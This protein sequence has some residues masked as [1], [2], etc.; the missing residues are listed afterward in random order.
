M[1]IYF[2]L[3]TLWSLENDLNSL[4]VSDMHCLPG[5]ILGTED[6]AAKKSESLI[7]KNMQSSQ[8]DKT[9]NRM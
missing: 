9:N 3:S 8:G 6:P 7:S 5:T 4:G 2:H 1:V